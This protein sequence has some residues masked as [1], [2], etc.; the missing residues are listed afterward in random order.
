MLNIVLP[1]AG[2]GS[3]F[4]AVGV[5]TP[6]PLIPVHG[7]PMIEW[8]ADNVRPSRPHRFIYLCLQEHLEQTAMRAVLNSITPGCTI[9]PVTHVTEGAACTVLLAR[10][11]IDNDQPLMLANSDQFVD[12]DIDDYLAAQDAAAADGLIMTFE[13]DHPKW[14]YVGFDA[15]GRVARVIE[16]EVISHE[17]TVGIYNFARGRD[18]VRA[19]DRMIERDLRVNGEFYV[20]PTYN[21][22]IEEG[23]SIVVHNVGSEGCGMYGLGIPE[24]L[25]VFVREYSR[26][27]RHGLLTA[28]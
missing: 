1:S 20:A 11:H 14:S 24:D 6:K 4:A 22:L 13:A 15:T 19:A 2:R 9:V 17:A 26:G 7:R 18:F 8:V 27:L 16:K 5:T 28:P 3:R 23:A 21:S 25:D 10:A 12:I